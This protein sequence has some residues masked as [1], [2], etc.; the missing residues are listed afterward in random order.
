MVD[1]VE[2]DRPATFQNPPQ[3]LTQRYLDIS[4]LPGSGL[5]W[6]AVGIHLLFLI[7]VEI[8]LVLDVFFEVEVFFVVPDPNGAEKATA[9]RLHKNIA[10]AARKASFAMALLQGSQTRMREKKGV[11]CSENRHREQYQRGRCTLAKLHRRKR[12]DG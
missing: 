5:S 11:A 3:L 8:L 2:F 12:P 6:L 1:E 4:V 7:A 9:A 10:H